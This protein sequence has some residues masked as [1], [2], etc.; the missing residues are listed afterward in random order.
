MGRIETMTCVPRSNER[1]IL[2]KRV[3]GVKPQPKSV[4]ADVY[5]KDC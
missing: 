2:Q 5:V 4:L 1:D 3:I